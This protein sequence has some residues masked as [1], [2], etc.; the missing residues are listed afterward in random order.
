MCM[1]PV[2]N[3]FYPKVSAKFNYNTIPVRGQN[4]YFNISAMVRW[5]VAFVGNM[6][7]SRGMHGKHIGC[8]MYAP[9]GR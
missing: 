4:L 6:F 7:C 2:A 3:E 8:N 1:L 9:C 5:R